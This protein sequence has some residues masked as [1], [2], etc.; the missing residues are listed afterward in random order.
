MTLSRE[1]RLA[2][3]GAVSVAAIVTSP[4]AHAQ[5]AANAGQN[6]EPQDGVGVSVV[7][8]FGA[9]SVAL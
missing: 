2:L 7:E 8:T 5:D 9:K 6:A 3:L 1:L 4:V